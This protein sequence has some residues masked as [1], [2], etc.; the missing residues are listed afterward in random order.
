MQ[1]DQTSSK[2][3][4]R[5]LAIASLLH[6]ANG[7]ICLECPCGGSPTC[8]NVHETAARLLRL[9]EIQLI[10]ARDTIAKLENALE[11]ITK[12]KSESIKQMWD[13][14]MQVQQVYS[15][16]CKELEEELERL[17]GR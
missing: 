15:N 5:E 2:P 4:T 12:S 17:K 6:C 11:D 14:M 10:E 3:V 9:D 8:E 1:N 16:R 13:S 7:S